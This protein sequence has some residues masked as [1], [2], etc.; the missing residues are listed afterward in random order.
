M[1]I[2]SCLVVK[3]FMQTRGGVCVTQVES[4]RYTG[5]IK[6]VLKN[7]QICNRSQRREKA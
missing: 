3:S 1:N 5:C 6:S 7:E 2:N 4:K